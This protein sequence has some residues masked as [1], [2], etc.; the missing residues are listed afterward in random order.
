MSLIDVCSWHD[1][2]KP[3]ICHLSEDK[4]VLWEFRKCRTESGVPLRLV[5]CGLR[6]ERIAAPVAGGGLWPL[7]AS[8]GCLVCNVE[9]QNVPCHPTPVLSACVSVRAR[10]ATLLYVVSLC[11]APLRLY[12]VLRCCDSTLCAAEFGGRRPCGL[13]CLCLTL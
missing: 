10:V 1:P 3:A 6:L 12:V 13:L 7:H 11:C 5:A 2:C 8:S 4:G 9:L